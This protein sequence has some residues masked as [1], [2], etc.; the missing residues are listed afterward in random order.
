MAVPWLAGSLVPA[1]QDCEVADNFFT[2]IFPAFFAG[3]CLLYLLVSVFVV[4]IYFAVN[5]L[6]RSK[7]SP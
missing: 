6:R 7:V 2:K 5:S 1:I 3:S 4:C